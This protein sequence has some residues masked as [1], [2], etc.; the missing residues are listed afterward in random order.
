MTE[1]KIAWLLP[2]SKLKLSINE[3]H[4][5]CVDSSKRYCAICVHMQSRNRYWCW[6]CPWHA[7]CWENCADYVFFVWKQ[8]A[9]KSPGKLEA[10]GFFLIAG[11]ARKRTLKR[12]ETAYTTPW[13][14]LMFSLAPGEPARPAGER[15]RKCSA[16][17]LLVYEIPNPGGRLCGCTGGKRKRF[18]SLLTGSIRKKISS[19]L[20]RFSLFGKLIKSNACP[21]AAWIN[22]QW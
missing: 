9:A 7:G 22:C 19:S 13:I 11:P 18:L 1:S 8:G 16:S 6:I 21:K 5:W 15:W 2:S 17:F 12:M 3:V 14:G 10:G 20:N 4:V